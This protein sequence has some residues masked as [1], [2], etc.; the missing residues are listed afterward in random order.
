MVWD[1]AAKVDRVC[2]NDM[3]LKGPNLLIPLVEVL[4]RFREGQI[5][6]CSDI[7]EK[8]LRILIRDEDNGHS[9]MAQ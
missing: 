9:A 7:R 4:L 8:F 1:T 3:L 2:F 5:V 6:V